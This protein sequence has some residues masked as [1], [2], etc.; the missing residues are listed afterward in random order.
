MLRNCKVREYRDLLA[1]GRGT[2]INQAYAPI[3]QAPD[4]AFLKDIPVQI[5]RNAASSA[6][7]DAEAARKG[8]SRFPK[9]KGRN[10]KRSG[11]IH[12]GV[13]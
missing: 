4:V 2:E 8:I 9:V 12:P 7:A 3:K 5:L 1:Q 13:V 11:I 6:Y 10:K